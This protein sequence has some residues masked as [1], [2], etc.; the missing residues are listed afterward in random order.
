MS[1]SYDN[2]SINQ[3]NN[4]RHKINE[5]LTQPSIYSDHSNSHIMIHLYNTIIDQCS[6]K[7]INID[8]NRFY[9]DLVHLIYSKNLEHTH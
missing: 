2:N 1:F 6:K 7:K 4:V 9:E 5:W 8:K 3:H